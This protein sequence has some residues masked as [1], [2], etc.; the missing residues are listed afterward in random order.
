MKAERHSRRLLQ[1]VPGQSLPVL[2]VWS[3]GAFVGAPATVCVTGYAP[4]LCGLFVAVVVLGLVMALLVAL[5][6]PEWFS[7]VVMGV[8]FPSAYIGVRLLGG[9][10]RRTSDR[11]C[12]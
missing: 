9:V 2:Y 3:L 8:V 7:V 12:S 1:A 6:H 5:P 10:T 4:V 11:G